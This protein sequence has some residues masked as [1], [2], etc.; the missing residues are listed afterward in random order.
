MSSLMYD[1]HL[2]RRRFRGRIEVDH[3][4]RSKPKGGSKGLWLTRYISPDNIIVSLARESKPYD[5]MITGALVQ[6]SPE[7]VFFVYC[8]RM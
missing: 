5:V 7:M 1:Q 4:A 2:H 3:R 8:G 6:N